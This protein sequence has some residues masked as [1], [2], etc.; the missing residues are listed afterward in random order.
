L[1]SILQPFEI[2]SEHQEQA[3]AILEDVDVDVQLNPI[4]NKRE[5]RPGLDRKRKSFSLHLT[6]R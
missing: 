5:R 6:T 4:P 3:K 2:Q 1:A